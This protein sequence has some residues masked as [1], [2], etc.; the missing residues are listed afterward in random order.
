[1]ML[2]ER[3][4]QLDADVRQR[5]KA[6]II[7]GSEDAYASMLAQFEKRQGVNKPKLPKT[8]PKPMQRGLHKGHMAFLAILEEHGP[9]YRKTLAKILGLAP[10]SISDYAARLEYHRLIRKTNMGEQS[11]LYHLVERKK[12]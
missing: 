2:E 12:K 5:A 3:N 6:V 1:M 9:T 7:P 11:T 10:S 4:D 8:E